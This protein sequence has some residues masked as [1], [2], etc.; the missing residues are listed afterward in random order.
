MKEYDYILASV[1]NPDFSNQDFKDI[2]GMNMEN[3]QILPY[4]SYTSS[5]FITQ[6]EAF[7][8]NGTFNEQKFKDFYTS[9]VGKFSTFN[10]DHPLVDNYEYSFFD[11]GRKANSRVRDP[12]FKLYT[13]SNPDRVSVGISGRNQRQESGFSRSELAQQSKIRNSE[14]GEWMDYSPNDMA[15]V[16]SP[17]KWFKS[18]FDDPLVLAKYD[19]DGEHKDPITKK[20]V[21]HH[22]GELKLNDDGQYYYETLG[23]RSLVGQEVLH[24]SD[25]L[26]VD[27]E[28]INK[29]DF[30]DSDGLDKSVTGTI[31]KTA[32]QV[33]PLLIGGPIATAYS[34]ALVGREMAKSL[35]MLYGM[36]SS[37]WGNEEDSKVLNTIAAYGDKFSSG[38]SEHASSKTF[39]FENIA[40]LIGDV[41]VQ[42]GQQKAIAKSINNLRGSD[43]LVEEAYQKAAAF[44]NL[45]ARSIQ[46]G[47]QAA[48]IQGE[49]K[50]L[51][52]LQYIGNPEKWYESALG[53]KAIEKFV[54][55]AQKI[56]Q[57]NMRLG[58]D[59]SLA[60]M[61]IVSNTDVYQSMLEHGA[62]KRDAAAIAF[63][64]T[65]GMFS[66]DRYLGLGEMFFD[67]L[68]NEERLAIR[69]VFRKEA[70]NVADKLIGTGE[71]L[72]ANPESKS[73]FKNL[74]QRG[75]KFS[76]GVTEQYVSDIKNH[77]T[78]F[79]GKALGE[80]L[81][82]VSEEVVTDLA[83]QIYQI[84]GEFEP[85]FINESGITKV[86]AFE[87]W[88]E[89]YSMSLLGGALGGGLF[90]GVDV[91]QNGTF[92]RDTSKDEL[93]YLVAN[94]K[95]PEL[96][97]E[98]ERWKKAGKF[99]NKTLSAT[100]YELDE[101]G[102]RIALTAENE[103]DSQNTF[104]YNRIK[105][106]IF[107]L[108]N[109]LN[110]SGTN[111]SEEELFQ[112]MVL[113]EQRLM[114]LKDFLQDQS[115]VT[116]Y[117]EEYR[118]ITR[119]LF[120]AENALQAAY[121]SKD[122]TPNGEPLPDAAGT[123]ALNDPIR[124]QNIENL[125]AK[126]EEL[127]ALRDSFNKGEKSLPYTE[128]MLFAVDNFLHDNFI[129]MTY[130]E[131]LKENKGKTID[132][133]SDSEKQVF[134]KEYLDYKRSEQAY[135]LDIAFNIYKGVQS[136]VNPHISELSEN[137]GRF[138]ENHKAL[139]KLYAEDSPFNKL[140]QIIKE[141]MQ[142]EGESDEDYANRNTQLEGESDEDFIDRRNKRIQQIED[143]NNQVI[144]SIKEELDEIIKEAG[145]Y[146]DPSTQR[147]I[148][149]VFTQ[150]RS[151]WASNIIENYI[152]DRQKLEQSKEISKV[153]EVM[154][155]L[156]PDMS[157]YGEV[158]QAMI[159]QAKNP[160]LQRYQKRNE[161][162]KPIVDSITRMFN[163]FGYQYDPNN[164]TGAT[165]IDFMNTLATRIQ[166]GDKDVEKVFEDID[167]TD[168]LLSLYDSENILE[169]LFQ[170][171]IHED[172]LLE[173]YLREEDDYGGL[174]EEDWAPINNRIR[175]GLD[176]YD[177]SI[178][179]EEEINSRV[180]EESRQPIDYVNYLLTDLRSKLESDPLISLFDTVDQAVTNTNP[181]TQLLKS[182]N[183]AIDPQNRSIESILDALYRKS[184]KIDDLNNFELTE[185]E[186]YAIDDVVRF[187]KM[188]RSYLYAASTDASFAFP[189]GH[190]KVINEFAKK[191]KDI[192]KNF[193]ELPTLDQS[194]ADMYMLEIDK[195]LAELD[196]N[197]PQSWISIANRNKI[198]KKQKLIDTEAK[199][200]KAKL[201]LLE[202]L[203]SSDS[204]K[205]II[206][207]KPY[208]LL[209]G[210][211]TIIDDDPAVRLHKIENLFYIKLRQA[212]ADG[213]TF[214][215]IL[216]ASHIL[217]TL[218]GNGTITSQITSELNENIEYGKLTKYDSFI[219]LLTISGISSNEFQRFI[220]ER[221]S[222]SAKE[223]DKNKKI[224]P[225]TIQEHTTRLALAQIKSKDIFSQALEY[226]KEVGDNGNGDL[227][228]ILDYLVF[229]DGSA[230][231]GKSQVIARYASKFIN[232]D[233]L[234]LCAPQKTQLETLKEVIG[235]GLSKVRKDLFDLILDPETYKKIMEQVNGTEQETDLFT[236]KNI[237]GN[238]RTT[239]VNLEKINF[240]EVSDLPELIIIDE[241]THFSD[242]ELQILNEFAKRKGISILALG[243]TNQNGFFNNTK[244]NIT[245][246]TIITTRSPKLSISLRDANIQKQQNLLN[247]IDILNKMRNLES[248]DADYKQKFRN[249]ASLIKSLN[250]Q[251]YNQ[252]EINGDLI[253]D[254]LTSEH[255]GKLFGS[256]AFVGDTQGEAYKTLQEHGDNI[257]EVITLQ[258]KEIQGQEFD[259]IVIDQK[260]IMET[261]F[262]IQIFR[263]LTDLYTM[264]SRGKIGSIF[265]DNGLSNIIGQNKISNSK[266][267]AP[268]LKD[269]ADE[270]IKKKLEF[271]EKIELLSNEEFEKQIEPTKKDDNKKS[272]EKNDSEDDSTTEDDT[273]DDT[274][275]DI[276]DDGQSF[277]E[278]ETLQVKDDGYEPDEEVEQDRRNMIETINDKTEEVIEKSIDNLSLDKDLPI[279]V[280][281]S[282][283]LAGL[284][285]TKKVV[286]GEEKIVYVNPHSEVKS[287]LQIFMKGEEA[288]GE[289]MDRLVRSMLKLKSFILYENNLDNLPT[290]VS[291]VVDAQHLK[292]IKYK[293]EVRPYNKETD[294]FVGFTGLEADGEGRNRID[295]I[296]GLV[297][298]LIGEFENNDGE[299][300]KI[301]L[302][303]LANPES[304][305]IYRKSNESE[306]EYETR[307]GL[308]ES[309]IKKYKELIKNIKT[310][311]DR[312]GKFIEEVTPKFSG[313]TGIRTIR[314]VDNQRVPVNPITLQ[315]FKAK[316][317]YTVVSDP[318]I[319]VGD[320]FKGLKSSKI[321][322]HA[323]VFVSNDLSLSPDELMDVYIRQKEAT[324]RTPDADLFDLDVKPRVRM[325]VLDNV[326]V[327][328]KSLTFTQKMKELYSVEQSFNGV[329][330]I[331]LFPFEEDYMGVRMVVSLWNYRAN[332]KKF[333]DAYKNFN[334]TLKDGTKLNDDDIQKIATYADALYKKNN[335][336]DS[337]LSDDIEEILRNSHIT[338]EKLMLLQSFNDSLASEVRQF[339]I[340]G[341][342]KSSGVYLR[343]LTNITKDNAFYRGLDGTPVGIYITLDAA[344]KH[345]N[346]I[347]TLL[348]DSLG[349]VIKLKDKNGNDWPETKN[350]SA[351]NGYVNSAS[352]LMEYGVRS[353]TAAFAQ[354]KEEGSMT[355]SVFEDGQEYELQL[356]NSKIFN[357]I[358]VI[359]QKIY[360][361][362]RRL[363]AG[364][365]EE[366]RNI[367]VG[368]RGNNPIEISYYDL[369]NQLPARPDFDEDFDE[370][371]DD[372]FDG[373]ND[374]LDNM[375]ALAFHGTTANPSRFVKVPGNEVNGKNSSIRATDAYFKNGFYIDPSAAQ[376]VGKT[377]SGEALFRKCLT[378][379]ALFTI[380]VDIDMPFFTVT[381][382]GLQ[383]AYDNVK[384]PKPKKVETV[385]RS[386]REYYSNPD[387]VP[388]SVFN[389][390]QELFS[391]VQSDEEFLKKS[392]EIITNYYQQTKIPTYIGNQSTIQEILNS[393]WK[394]NHDPSQQITVKQRIEEVCGKQFNI[395]NVSWD[396]GKILVTLQEGNTLININVSYNKYSGDFET[397]ITT[398]T[399]EETIN[400][401]E[402]TIDN[403]I[404][405]TQD[406]KKDD[407]KI[408]E[409]VINKINEYMQDENNKEKLEELEGFDKDAYTVLTNIDEYGTLDDLKN[410]LNNLTPIFIGQDAFEDILGI[411]DPYTSKTKCT[412]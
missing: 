280:Y 179:S 174:T 366:Y 80:G 214:K 175:F 69:S 26:T 367:I 274:G 305:Q 284:V 112:Q 336:S 312:E 391:T 53:K 4:S 196:P 302:G 244:L 410:A 412:T 109:F 11:T 259:F 257:K 265:I 223:E 258:P 92:K 210:M 46:Q 98:L 163:D 48:L 368:K 152:R 180:E 249:L 218:P 327:S 160:I 151:D 346:L 279:R 126:V 287:D 261:E 189:I 394:Y 201:Q 255:V 299:K 245:R 97:K 51:S 89:R 41:A 306:S 65:L 184:L 143:H 83:K 294:N 314:I 57:R 101:N 31:A 99:G 15:L 275:D 68:R 282:A 242:V 220:K 173:Y 140:S 3:T 5:P 90:Y 347:N 13:V 402:V 298:S 181:I 304:Y 271:Y 236:T 104:I 162:L 14:T 226:L 29:Y 356:P 393:I 111:L 234:W 10:E 340:G 319:Y 303:L 121:K 81:E 12:E 372:D 108:E 39:A 91:Y 132:Q 72:I 78:G 45:E 295:A 150:R 343:N 117:Q 42:W 348:N 344:N 276:E 290:E 297:Y 100:R 154:R 292:N 326:G 400:N 165:V 322:G 222:E 334:W 405:E 62:S 365:D 93:I 47:A 266:E 102:N 61:A 281:G 55:P 40:A 182:I 253:T 375:L 246:E 254:K 364:P 30:I 355:L 337:D 6:N 118:T 70:D 311:Y 409:I 103:D 230:G 123:V 25:I 136:I 38:V 198:N 120:D 79:F 44:Y 67:E 211:N 76:K 2:I 325:L 145:G 241:I 272:E 240:N 86:G 128:K 406:D 105:E 1:L 16:N 138:E 403:N 60:Y 331:K 158:R 341:S 330:S 288:D 185:N 212:L 392:S 95:T 270:F 127:R 202:V 383:E 141:D 178:Y 320:N 273:N 22:K 267:K 278:D 159:D 357:H 296:N 131:W 379:P 373:F 387:N 110:Q 404:K 54:Q 135:N 401:G 260:W 399:S 186:E 371:L 157:N 358:P 122:G 310:I 17:I 380:G 248:T 396:N 208:D 397:E 170:F 352:G 398:D 321:R 209:E 52:P 228:P 155:R 345:Y 207:G 119:K 390:I 7:Q 137:A 206:K 385:S 156:N 251:V 107:Q 216:E 309:K 63:G 318:Y 33:A 395:D 335:S 301:T 376:V 277:K 225:L 384:N 407:K 56:A 133:L 243:D 219:Y 74:I 195:Y 224:V 213:V 382:G 43:K 37:L 317:P 293:I 307:K 227:R 114:N 36:V 94:K 171:D 144:K 359:L 168:F 147:F 194:V 369:V 35:P 113:S 153:L 389:D 116:G 269:S 71:G 59:A 354:S 349:E 374:D 264:M 328:F 88:L 291:S 139:Q 381:I 142:L 8:D 18:L 408:L 363:Q 50:G 333:L 315:N 388:S 190:N 204:L 187:L 231:V 221:V 308:H 193:E 169:D 342:R 197:I 166:A 411:V 350:I 23:G 300:C 370:D 115:Y 332:L 283:H 200:N 130:E 167:R 129:S 215:E 172:S 34:W 286:N 199:Y 32:L 149:N 24:A 351:N 247:I 82:E 66:V 205:F 77:S 84:A 362:I 20:M 134:K 192:Y 176:E 96:L 27:G 203:N 124:L 161:E 377:S 75:M 19:E 268:N 235:K 232:S 146:I 250:F 361:N 329:K 233:K 252:D 238:N 58:A 339:R 49:L 191:N 229:V 262:D 316:N 87:N 323:V 21:Q 64:S 313:L 164:I 73:K 9:T 188:V 183:I 324:A 338:E 177:M 106:S 285:R 386:I 263:F 148:H 239:V 360:G 125:Q 28:G 85:N 378:N 256:V 289:T 353:L 217:E 237:P